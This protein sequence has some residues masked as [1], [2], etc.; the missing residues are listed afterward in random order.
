MPT[1]SASVSRYLFLHIIIYYRP[2]VVAVFFVLFLR[3]SCQ[4]AVVCNLFCTN[5]EAKA[6][7]H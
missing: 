6:I 4:K 7:R 3:I 1:Y 5:D 2:S